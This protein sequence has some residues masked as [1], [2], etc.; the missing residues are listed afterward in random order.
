MAEDTND[1][2]QSD[3]KELIKKSTEIVRYRRLQRNANLAIDQISMCLP[4]FELYSSLQKLMAN[5]K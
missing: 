2:I 5:K 4:A 3:S 1:F